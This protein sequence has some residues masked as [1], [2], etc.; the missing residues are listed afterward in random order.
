MPVTSGQIITRGLTNRCPNCGRRT[1]FRTWFKMNER[2]PVC[3]MRFEHS[4]DGFFLAAAVI[5]YTVTSVL[6]LLPLG[7]LVFMGKVDVLPAVILAV[8]GCILFPALFHHCA[9]SWW[10]MTYYLFFPR[11]LPAN[12]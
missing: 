4:N 3:G 9:W 11:Q 1:L 5:N 6:L 7:V 2:C 12:E 10:L 8:A